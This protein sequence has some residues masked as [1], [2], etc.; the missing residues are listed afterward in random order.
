MISA[1]RLYYDENRPGR[2]NL[3]P[4]YFSELKRKIMIQWVWF[5]ETLST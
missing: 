1:G 4:T 2:P 3:V 5:T